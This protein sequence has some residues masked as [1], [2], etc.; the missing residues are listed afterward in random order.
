[1]VG[2]RDRAVPLFVLGHRTGG[3]VATALAADDRL[4]VAGLIV[5]GPASRITPNAAIAKATE[6]ARSGPDGSSWPWVGAG[7]TPRAA[8]RR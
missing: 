7:S 8:T 1:V 4:D 5:L 6:V 3:L 2:A